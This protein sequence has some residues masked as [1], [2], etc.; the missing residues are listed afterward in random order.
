MRSSIL[1]ARHL[2]SSAEGIGGGGGTQQ[3]TGQ[4]QTGQVDPQQSTATTST[5]STSATERAWPA[6]TP[7]AEMTIE[8]QLAYTKYHSHKHETAANQYRSLGDVETVRAKI[9]AADAAEQ[10]RLTPSEQAIAAAKAEGKA[11]ALGAAAIAIV[12]A[13][14][15]A[16]GKT[17]EQA[18]L[19]VAAV[20]TSAFIADGKVDTVKV[21][22]FVNEFAGPAGSGQ[23]LDMGQGTRGNRTA[24]TGVDAGRDLYTTSRGKQKTS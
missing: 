2:R 9:A 11:E 22:T 7:V 8:Q 13:N 21:S 4:Q 15:V 12:E 3:Q 20:N 24:T 17:A 19:I 1:S 14:L 23:R 10:A 18:A 6:D 5:T 16:R